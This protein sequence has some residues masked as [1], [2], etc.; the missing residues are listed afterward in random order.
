MEGREEKGKEGRV[1]YGKKREGRGERRRGLP[2]FPQFQICHY[3]TANCTS[4][5]ESS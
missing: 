5:L 1:D 2:A 3:I 4:A